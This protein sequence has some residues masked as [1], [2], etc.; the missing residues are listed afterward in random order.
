MTY[1][2]KA[3]FFTIFVLIMA[4]VMA[5]AIISF[6]ARTSNAYVAGSVPTSLGSLT[7]SDYATR[8]DGKV[9]DGEVL[10]AL[11]DAILG[12]S[13]TGTYSKV[14][15][16]VQESS[17][18]TTGTSTNAAWNNN[19]Q[20]HSIN[21][22]EIAGGNPITIELGGYKWNIVYLTTNTNANS[23]NG[24]RAGDLI[25]TLWMAENDAAVGTKPWSFGGTS[26]T[27][28]NQT[29]AANEYGASRIRIE[30]LNNGNINNASTQ[31]ANSYTAQTT[32]SAANRV[33]NPYAKFTMSN[34][35][36]AST[37]AKNTSLIEFLATPSQVEYQRAENW[38]WSYNGTGT[39]YLC[40]N[41]AWGNGTD[42][43]TGPNINLTHTGGGKGW[44]VNGSTNMN[45]VVDNTRYYEWKDDYLWLPSLTETGY[46]NSGT[47][48]GTS[49]WGIP[50][51][52]AILKSSGISWLRSGNTGNAADARYL[53]APGGKLSATS[54][55]AY[56]VRPALHLNLTS[57]ALSATGDEPNSKVKDTQI[58]QPGSTTFEYTGVEAD[59]S[60]LLKS[61]DQAAWYDETLHGNANVVEISTIKY[62][63]VS[64]KQTALS[65]SSAIIKNAGKYEVVMRLKNYSTGS[66]TAATARWRGST[67]RDATFTITITQKTIDFPEWEGSSEQPFAGGAEVHFA[68]ILDEQYADS[69]SI[70]KPS[71]SQYAD[72][73]I[74]DYGDVYAKDVGDYALNVALTGDAANN[75]KFNDPSKKLTFKVVPATVKLNLTDLVGGTS[76]TSGTVERYP[77]NIRVDAN[78]KV[79]DGRQIVINIYAVPERGIRRPVGSATIDGNTRELQ[80]DLNFKNLVNGSRY[81]LV[82]EIDESADDGKSYAVQQESVTTLSVEDGVRTMITW[83][84]YCDGQSVYNQ[85]MDVATTQTNVTF[86]GDAIVYDGKEYKFT[87]IP[88]TD[89]FVDEGYGLD[90]YETTAA[91]SDNYNLGINADTYVTT[92]WLSDGSSTTQ[93][94]ITWTVQ[95]A[96][97]DLSG[98][99]W[100]HDGKLPYTPGGI[101]CVLNSSTLPEGLLA[102]YGGINTGYTVGDTG[103]ASVEFTL[104]A[105]YADNYLLPVQG[106]PDTY[107]FK[108]SG[109]L[110]D[111]EWEKDWSV[112][113][114]TIQIKW[115]KKT[116]QDKNGNDFVSYV[117]EDDK[118]VIAYHFYE[119][120]ASG[121]ILDS[122]VFLTLDE[123]ELI[124]NLR[125][126]YKVK[127]VFINDDYANNYILPD[128]YSQHFEFGQFAEAVKIDVKNKTLTYNGK[129]Q[130]V[131]IDI[132]EGTI[133]KDK[134][135]IIYYDRGATG[136]LSAAPS[137]VGLYTAEI[138]IKSG[139]SGFYLTGDNV[140]GGK[141]IIDFEI[142]PREI[143]N[144]SW[145]TSRNPPC[146][147]IQYADVPGILYEYADLD[148]N[149]I[150]FAQLVPGNSY[151]VRALIR[152]RNNYKFKVAFGDDNYFETDW[153]EFTVSENEQL[154]DPLDPENPF[155]PE[156]PDNP[157]NP[158]GDNPPDGDNPSGGGSDVIDKIKDFF[159]NLI[160]NNFP[161]WQVASS[162]VAI[163]LSLI[164][165][166]KTLQYGSR[167]KKAKGEAKRLNAKTYSALLPI[168]AADIVWLN[169][170]NKIWSI[171]AFSIIGFTVFMFFVMLITRRG[172]KKAELAKQTAIE[173]SE[174]RK[175]EAH[176]AKQLAREEAQE[177]R[178]LAFTE[179]ISQVAAPA[180]GDNSAIL[181]AMRLEMEERRREAAEREER[182]RQEMARRDEEQS[183]RD[184]AMKLMFANLMGRNQADD[185]PYASIDNGDLLVQKVI[186]GLLPAVQQML[187]DMAYLSAPSEQ[188]EELK[189]LVEEQRA[190]VEEQKAIVD[191]QNEEIRNMSAQ[192]SDLQD[193]LYAMSQD[194]VEGVLLPDNSD[195]MRDLTAQIA[196]LQQQL[197]QMSEDRV[198]GVL[199]PD[200]SDEMLALAEQ[201]NAEMRA[202]TDKM[203]ELQ[204]QLIEMS[205][206]RVEGVLLPDNSDEMRELAEQHNA[207]MRAVT[208]KMSELQQQLID[209]SQN[210]ND[211]LS[212]NDQSEEIKALTAQIAELQDRLIDITQDMSDAAVRSGRSDELRNMA[213]EH[214]QTLRNI[215]AEHAAEIKAMSAEHSAEMQAMS[216]EMNEMRSQLALLAQNSA[217]A[218]ADRDDDDDFDDDEEEW[219]SILDEDDDDFVD[220]V[221]I[222]ED[223]TVKKTYPNFRMR[224]KQ[225][226]DKNREWYAAV[227][228]LF[229]SQKGVTY[230]VYKRV[231]K[232][233][234]QGQVIAVI[235]IAKR[236]IKLWL[237]L[238]PYEYDAR[239]YHHK[240]VSDK[241]RFV[242]VPMY[243]RVSSDR[244]L[245]RAQELILALFQELNMEAR[246]RYN[247]RSIQELIFTLK[248][249]K[250]LTNKQNKGLLCEVMHVHDCDVLSDELAEKC[251]ESKNVEIIDES[252]IETLKLD[253]IDAKFQDGNRV[254]LEKLKK[255]GLVSEECT[256][257]TVTAGHRLT[258]PLIIVANDFTLPAVKMITL[259]GGRA[260]KLT[261]I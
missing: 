187:P 226:S 49:L 181:E 245:T 63:D 143:D 242:D 12:V 47:D 236:S 190:L 184:E 176:E 180:A 179:R 95:K 138:A 53:T 249:N 229:C 244:A 219:D 199:L 4:F 109:D 259:T 169:L 246:K 42:G 204:Q 65:P 227:K 201:H 128:V 104:G 7:L 195:E 119:T 197:I 32:V 66:S 207:E 185:I 46:Y 60:T 209:M 99:K 130:N 163:L 117:L 23:S 71:T 27:A 83:Q 203:T 158:G 238:K 41:E 1:K 224:L 101:E 40:P 6:G 30:T 21:F 67:S 64:G 154:Y 230:R 11:Y 166:I 171:I 164:F 191:R 92:V 255:V 188:N 24:G 126:F 96:K 165:L 76:L 182:Y 29:Y 89:Y 159:D 254:T 118:G 150:A 155:F 18:T 82:A 35:A 147:D 9:F 44:Y 77:A 193:Q 215:N 177:A 257:Y 54:S 132:L 258:K 145:I 247:D 72:V 79:H 151:K 251:I 84:L 139:V 216:A 37:A 88:P 212:A 228:N 129:Q 170:S 173:D 38:V 13:G 3:K 85:Y 113:K 202:V 174:Q 39:P 73:R 160:K 8:T 91:N 26:H 239:R 137:N 123:M 142:V 62:T 241:P 105:E 192:V 110:A 94:K 125:K 218:A 220:A 61:G 131:V 162:A 120:N 111:F 100:Q 248:H 148:G 233:R 48:L 20:D 97:F 168:F 34:S 22:S 80:V 237:A 136:S 211:D 234:Y 107:V 175:L 31:Y 55:T 214:S 152:D 103:K 70:T 205:Q 51:G 253:D 213:A 43:V 240:D 16:K 183:K 102:V 10:A 217:L 5:S 59:L 86:A 225:S 178:Q 75:F 252:Y 221:I 144:S 260:I 58:P 122:S 14:L 149:V 206:D 235:G 172:W 141:A 90:G 231:E 127:P 243:V 157:D 186:A 210:K 28:T 2:R 140:Q 25:A 232:I 134:F 189:A 223:G 153:I 19:V 124:E 68:V 167:R 87:V 200:N 222:E 108:P 121:S 116:L 56:A 74:T 50:N 106:N 133:G 93:Y 17:S 33:A 135:D 78:S 114:A 161:L 156:D 194:R 36:L 69:L 115:V 256:G 52:N 198:E 98:I 208:D 45:Q 112:V 250:L 261:K 81:T 57:V 146:L 15:K 196:Q